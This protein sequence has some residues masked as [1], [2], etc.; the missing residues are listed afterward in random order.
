MVSL[1]HRLEYSKN[2]K[3]VG[4]VVFGSAVFALG[5]NLFLAP[6]GLNA[7]GLSGAAMVITHLLGFGSVGVFTALMNVP[8]FIMGYRTIGRRFFLMSLLGMTASSLLLD[9][10][11]LL[12]APETDP[13]LGALA[14][15]LASGYGIG[16][17]FIYGASTGGADMIARLLKTKLPGFPMGRLIFLVDLVVVTLTGVVFQDWNKTLYSAI[18]LYVSSLMVDRLI[19]GSDHSA[20]A[21]IISEQYEAIASAIGTRL[22]RGV[23]I[24][25]GT[26][27]HTGKPRPVLMCAV[28]R[29]QVALLK[30]LVCGIDP[31]AFVILQEAHQV[32]GSGFR[33]YSEDDL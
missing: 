6:N 25:P 30:S 4:A 16:L 3:A 23:T 14:G 33:R 18:T 17:V 27:H 32:L 22:N 15:G 12:P 8:L 9:V 28:R 11:S 31:E 13:L 26:G 21:M 24:L 5:F 2:L 1:P 10:M 19:Y 29:Q 20:V 7:G